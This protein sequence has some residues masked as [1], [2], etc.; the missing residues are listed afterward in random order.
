MEPLDEARCRQ[1]L[2]LSPAPTLEQINQA[3]HRLKRLYEDE[4]AP[5]LAPSMDEF[6][7]EV[8]TQVLAELEAAHRELCRCFEA[9]HP[10]IRRVPLPVLDEANLP[11]DGP[12]LRKLREASGA[13][14]EFLASETN[15]RS[16]F[17]KALEDERF[18]DLPHAAVNVR[19]FLT[20][21][22]NQLGLPAEAIVAGYMHRY[23]HWQA[24]HPR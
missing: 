3:Y 8:R 7:D 9:A 4:R 5:F 23:Q 1:I 2:E 11:M 19:G 13:T 20:A 6:S 10:Q 17:L 22:V 18:E 21:Y 15:V 14:L 24:S 12:G 16:D